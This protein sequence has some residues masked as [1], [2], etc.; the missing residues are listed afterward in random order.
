[1]VAQQCNASRCSAVPVLGVGEMAGPL[2][3][4]PDVRGLEI[5]RL[6]SCYELRLSGHVTLQS[7][8]PT[9]VGQFSL[10]GCR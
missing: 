3:L 9:L 1:M 8:L 7:L 4:A 10:M 6:G 5:F 2:I